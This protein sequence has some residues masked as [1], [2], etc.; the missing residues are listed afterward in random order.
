MADTVPRCW[1]R[2]VGEELPT[3]AQAPFVDV[4]RWLGRTSIVDIELRAALRF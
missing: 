3:L 2:R 4:I 1:L